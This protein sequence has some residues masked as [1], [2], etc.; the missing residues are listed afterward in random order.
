MNRRALVILLWALAAINGLAAVVLALLVPMPHPSV[1][2]VQQFL[3]CDEQSCLVCDQQSCHELTRAD[4]IHTLAPLGV[5]AFAILGITCVIWAIAAT[6]TTQN[7]PQAPY[8][9][10][11]YYGPP[12]APP[13]GSSY[14]QPP[15]GPPYA[16]PYSPPYGQP[17]YAPPY[18]GPQVP[19][20]QPP[21]PPGTGS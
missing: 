15:Y 20:N 13:Y 19:G 14:G 18:P 10:P 2:V 8:Q 17:P 1:V 4:V 16:P 12:Y 5:T 9:P 3:F 6:R 7:R 11:V 21:P